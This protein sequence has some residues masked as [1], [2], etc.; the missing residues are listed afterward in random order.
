M[1]KRQV[2]DRYEA[3]RTWRKERAAERG[4]ESDVIMPRETLWVLAREVPRRV[5]ELDDIPGLGP[6]RRAEYGDELIA[7]LK[8]ATG[9]G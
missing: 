7:L 2:Q 8:R 6:W 5:E 3:L 9:E 4:V 1:Y